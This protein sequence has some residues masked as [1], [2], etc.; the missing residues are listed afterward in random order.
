MYS[1]SGE[2]YRILGK[3]VKEKLGVLSFYLR[4]DLRQ[5]LPRPEMD[6]V[7][8]KKRKT[9]EDKNHVCYDQT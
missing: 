6:P 7:R 5:G 3:I 2:S 8:G 1:W 4:R 9:K